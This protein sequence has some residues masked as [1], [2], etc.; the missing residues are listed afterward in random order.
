MPGSAVDATP[1]EPAPHW[2]VTPKPFRR[3]SSLRLSG[4][5]GAASVTPAPTA[6][7]WSPSKR[8]CRGLAVAS[9]QARVRRSSPEQGAAA[10]CMWLRDARVAR[11]ARGDEERGSSG[12]RRG[13]LAVG[14]ACMEVSDARGSSPAGA[15][16]VAAVEHVIRAKRT[17]AG[18]AV[19]RAAAGR[20][21]RGRRGR[22]R[23]D[24]RRGAGRG[25]GE[26]DVSVPAGHG[27][28]RGR[29]ARWTTAA[30]GAAG[31]AGK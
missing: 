15:L 8:R 3:T 26:A 17:A 11:T 6:A 1:K 20:R 13:L 14:R 24:T 4:H 22:G 27:G 21:H 25:R 31:R 7:C 9:E 16:T 12:G 5:C 18:R 10:A 28:E 19:G 29:G 2:G 30:D 23:G